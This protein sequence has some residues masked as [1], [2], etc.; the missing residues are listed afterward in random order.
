MCACHDQDHPCAFAIKQ[1]L[2]QLSQERDTQCCLASRCLM[3]PG[4]MVPSTLTCYVH[5]NAASCLTIV[6]PGHM[7]GNF[8]AQPF[9]HSW[10]LV[11][12]PVH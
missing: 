1:F 8:T 6:I 12:W 10:N 4:A 3:Q 2:Q 9:D 11:P 7:C 5:T